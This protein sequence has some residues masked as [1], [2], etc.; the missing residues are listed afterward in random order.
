MQKRLRLPP[1]LVGISTEMPKPAITIRPARP[2][3]VDAVTA[4]VKAAYAMYLTR[5]GYP[6]FPMVADYRAMIAE[7]PVWVVEGASD[8]HC[9]AVLVVIPH[10]DHLLIEN[11]A[12]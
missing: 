6:P 2:S 10:T 1:S 9:A 4:C 3:D 11:I 8:A 12:V 7:H 5:L